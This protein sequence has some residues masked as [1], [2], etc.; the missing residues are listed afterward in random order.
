MGGSIFCCNSLARLE[1]G[2]SRTHIGQLA[3]TGG[4]CAR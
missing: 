3:L 4:G 1:S 2:A